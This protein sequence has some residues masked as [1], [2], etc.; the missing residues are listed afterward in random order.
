MAISVG[1]AHRRNEWGEQ[2][3]RYA[4]RLTAFCAYAAAVAFAYV[5]FAPLLWSDDAAGTATVA[6]PPEPQLTTVRRGDTLASVAARNGISVAR[7]LALNPDLEPL[8]LEP[9]QKL[10]VP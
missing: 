2:G 6:P 8:G 5:L 7:L 1:R 10:R 9:R 4:T 3:L